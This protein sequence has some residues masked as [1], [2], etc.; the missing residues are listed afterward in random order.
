MSKSITAKRP[1]KPPVFAKPHPDFP[2]TP[3]VRAKQWC[4]KIR[5]N[6]HYFGKLDNRDAALDK[7]LADKDDLL[8]GRKPRSKREGLEV[9]DLC[10][11]F[12][13]A[14]TRQF[15]AGELTAT[16]FAEYRTTTD[17]VVAAFGTTRLVADLVDG[18]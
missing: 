6:T 12:L 17:A 7:W 11:H 5:G 14:K 1:R 9:Y 3:H 15:E 18:G 4:K 2:L 13:T 8:A 16:T 10:N